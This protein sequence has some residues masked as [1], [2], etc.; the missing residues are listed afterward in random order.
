M[1]PIIPKAK[2]KVVIQIDGKAINN[3]EHEH[4]ENSISNDEGVVA[5]GEAQN[6]ARNQ[7][8]GKNIIGG[9]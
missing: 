1:M 2:P 8:N 7:N 3:E 9:A 4:V 5:G 6:D